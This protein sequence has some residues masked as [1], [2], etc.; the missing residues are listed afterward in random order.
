MNNPQSWTMESV[1]SEIQNRP[2]SDVTDYF[3]MVKLNNKCFEHLVN[4]NKLY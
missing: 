3:N 1:T 2:S 4:A